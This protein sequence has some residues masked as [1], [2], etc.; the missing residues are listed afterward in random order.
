[1]NNRRQEYEK[2]YGD[3]LLIVARL[4]ALRRG[5]GQKVDPVVNAAMRASIYA[6]WTLWHDQKNMIAPAFTEVAYCTP[7]MC[8]K[9]TPGPRIHV[10][11]EMQSE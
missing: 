6:A 2:V 5:E 10:P 11:H 7:E 3:L 4:D 1:M 8:T 9:R